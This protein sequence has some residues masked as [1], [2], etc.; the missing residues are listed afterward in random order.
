MQPK[1]T[2]RCIVSVNCGN[3]HGLPN[4]NTYC[5][6]GGTSRLNWGQL[7]RS[8]RVSLYIKSLQP[9]FSPDRMSAA[10]KMD[11]DMEEKVPLDLE[12][13]AANYR[14]QMKV[15]RLQQIAKTST[16]A[17]LKSDAIRMAYA[18]VKH[19]TQ[20]VDS[21]MKICQLAKDA[22]VQGCDDDH[23][24]CHMVSLS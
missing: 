12:A 4:V 20:N 21:F 24:W 2:S 5:A 7:Q 18:E 10:G 9:R 22:L 3:G 8:W 23:P 19:K 15:L 17:A 14:G 1:C 13:H 11:I 16:S 6:D